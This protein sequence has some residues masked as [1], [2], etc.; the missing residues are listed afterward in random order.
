VIAEIGLGMFGSFLINLLS[1]KLGALTANRVK[2]KKAR[3]QVF[4]LCK[5]MGSATLI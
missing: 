1:A 3:G 2:K 4:D 5:S